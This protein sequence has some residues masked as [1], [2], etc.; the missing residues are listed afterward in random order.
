MRNIYYLGIIL[1]NLGTLNAQCPQS[2]VIHSK[3]DVDSFLEEFPDCTNLNSLVLQGPDATIQ[4]LD[5]LKIVGGISLFVTNIDTLNLENEFLINAANITDNPKLKSISVVFQDSLNRV[6][7]TSNPLLSKVDVMG[8][9]FDDFLLDSQSENLVSL[10]FKGAPGVKPTTSRMFIKGK[11]K[12]SGLKLE[13]LNDLQI[14]GATD[15]FNS[16]RSIEHFLDFNKIER[17]IIS[18]MSM[19]SCH[20]ITQL[21]NLSSILF[22]LVQELDFESVDNYYQEISSVQFF[23]CENIQDLLPWSNC[24]LKALTVEHCPNL[25]SIEGVQFDSIVNFIRLID[26]ESLN[27]LGSMNN[28]VSFYTTIGAE[29]IYIQDNPNMSW[30]SY[31][32]VCNHINE[33]PERVVIANNK[34]HCKTKEDVAETCLSNTVNTNDNQI[35]IAPNPNNGLFKIFGIYGEAELTVFSMSGSR[36]AYRSISEN[37]ELDLSFLSKGTYIYKIIQGKNTTIGKFIIL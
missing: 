33:H 37:E 28:I 29:D 35:T 17:F 27:D 3:E 7:I 26:N 20:G 4:G 21:Q 10:I 22:N 23:N 16:F 13:V 14:L 9:N 34:D 25:K 24:V 2:L 1:L 30:C 36:V 11:W 32:V 6:S 8:Q 18:D 12:I 19:F 31:D 15:D 5:Q